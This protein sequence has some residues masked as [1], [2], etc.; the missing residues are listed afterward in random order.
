MKGLYMSW[1]DVNFEEVNPGQ[2]LIPEGD[3]TFL[4]ISANK[5]KFQPG[6]FDVRLSIA[7]PGPFQ[8]QSVFLKYPKLAADKNNPNGG[9]QNWVIK[10]FKLFLEAVKP[11]GY[12]MNTGEEPVD[13]VNRI[14]NEAEDNKSELYIDARIGHESYAD[15]ETGEPVTRHK[16]VFRSVKPTEQVTA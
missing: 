2:D 5:N 11:F 4:V 15:K 1:T 16:V 3:Y 6:A 13:F 9:P 8:G 7:S 12:K 10:A 14:T